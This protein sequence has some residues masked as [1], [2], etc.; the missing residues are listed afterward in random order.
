MFGFI[1]GKAQ[2]N[3][4]SKDRFLFSYYYQCERQT[5]KKGR[6]YPSIDGRF[7]LEYRRKY[8]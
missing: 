2:K 4:Y 7:I 1:L 3:V 5:V 8:E 6:K